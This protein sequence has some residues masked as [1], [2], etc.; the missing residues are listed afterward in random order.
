M[1][2]SGMS[3]QLLMAYVRNT[4]IPLRVNNFLW[5]TLARIEDWTAPMSY[6]LGGEQNKNSIVRGG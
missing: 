6:F 5:L 1:F 3:Y 2:I 4:C